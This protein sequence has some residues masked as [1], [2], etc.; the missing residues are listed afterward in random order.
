MTN[1]LKE[2]E[3]KKF[4]ALL[5]EWAEFDQ[6]VDT[7]E[8][9]ARDFFDLGCTFAESHAEGKEEEKNLITEKCHGVRSRCYHSS[10]DAR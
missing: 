8:A 4:N 3:D 2:A 6:T 10:R 1:Q 7:L 9:V 5:D